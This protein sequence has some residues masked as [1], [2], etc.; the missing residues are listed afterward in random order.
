M[1]KKSI[2]QTVIICAVFTAL[3]WIYFSVVLVPTGQSNVAFSKEHL[4]EKGV[5]A[6]Q[7][8][9]NIMQINEPEQVEKQQMQVQIHDSDQEPTDFVQQVALPLIRKKSNKDTDQNNAMPNTFDT[10]SEK[11][12]KEM[13]PK[14]KAL[15][16]EDNIGGDTTPPALTREGGTFEEDHVKGKAIPEMENM[17][18]I[19][20]SD[21]ENE[22][23]NSLNIAHILPE[24]TQVALNQYRQ[25]IASQQLSNALNSK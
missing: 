10:Y 11:T 6:Q 1:A 17:V 14:I 24:V 21:Y 18:Y 16:N 22:E 19:E 15:K 8:V 25:N 3:I 13:V 2:Q 9:Q 7:S 5:I 23:N 12:T 20:K 4:N